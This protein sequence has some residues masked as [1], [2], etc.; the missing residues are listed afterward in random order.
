MNRARRTII[1]R[2]IDLELIVWI[3]G[4]TWLA[5]M[6]P[7]SGP[8]FSFCILKRLRVPWCPGCG[9]GRSISFLFHGD[10]IAS[11]KTHPLGI[12]ALII[13]LA[14]IL[15]LLKRLLKRTQQDLTIS[16]NI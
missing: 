2:H 14:R 1:T 16:S 3:C 10:L 7:D 4:L 13:L 8:H 9:L 11:I 5:L 12:T 15:K 6:D